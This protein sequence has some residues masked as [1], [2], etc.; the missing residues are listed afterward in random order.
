MRAFLFTGGDVFDDGVTERVR[1]GDLVI[2]ADSGFLT[3]R[4]FG[5]TPHVLVGDMDSLGSADVPDSVEV[6]KVPAEK[7]DTDTQLA[8]SVALSRGADEFVIVGGLEG[9]LDHTLSSLSVLED[10][11]DRRVPAVFTSGRNRARFLRNSGVI[12]LRE[13]FTYF[14]IIAVD[15]VLKGVSVEGA[16]YPLKNAK[17]FRSHQFAVS[18]EISGNCALVEIR[19]GTA[20]VVESV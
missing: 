17:L 14:S 19:R 3:A 6:I 11:S 2:A 16:K 5:V 4:R 1:D 10:L 9:R 18:N 12:L 15:P 8:V 7:D 13:H 20:F